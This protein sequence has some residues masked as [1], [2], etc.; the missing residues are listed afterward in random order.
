MADRATVIAEPRAVLGKHVAKLRREGL[1]PAN[2]YGR[3]LDSVALQ[4][5]AR[6]FTRLLRAGAARGMFE[7]KV[8][9]EPSPRYVILRGLSRKG[10]TGDPLHA[11]FLQVDLQRPIETH[12]PIHLTGES[13]AVRD[14]AGLLVQTLEQVT[15]RCL[16]LGIPEALEADLS[17]LTGFGTALTV[18][19]LVAI[20]G[21][22]VVTD[23]SLTV[24]TANPP[25][26]R[27]DVAADQGLA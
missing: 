16:P 21:V 18:A 13:P 8:T 19:D 6:E 22:E 14:L 12:V 25:R 2:V 4:L 26:I 3:G 24:A 17:V 5:D 27:R 9:G 1:L 10:G 23:A 7:L 20:D 15:V 11:D